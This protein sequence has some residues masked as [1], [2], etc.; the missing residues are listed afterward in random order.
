MTSPVYFSYIAY[1]PSNLLYIAICCF[2]R[3]ST[4]GIA[5]ACYSANLSDGLLV[6][7]L[8][9]KIEKSE[10]KWPLGYCKILYIDKSGRIHHDRESC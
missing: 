4:R 5:F 7:F 1:K 10:K 8:S 2:L 9:K 3:V 6:E